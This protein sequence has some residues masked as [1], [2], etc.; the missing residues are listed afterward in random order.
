[1]A[2]IFDL[3]QPVGGRAD[4]AAMPERIVDGSADGMAPDGKV[5]F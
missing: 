2:V 3:I 4:D 1:M 5:R